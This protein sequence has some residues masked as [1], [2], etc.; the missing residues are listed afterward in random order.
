MSSPMYSGYFK[1]I[2]GRNITKVTGGDFIFNRVGTLTIENNN[3]PNM[4][5]FK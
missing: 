1:N 5:S 4:K 3:S 2:P